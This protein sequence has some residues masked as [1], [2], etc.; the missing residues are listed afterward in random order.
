MDSVLK[1]HYCLLYRLEN[2]C[3]NVRTF[4]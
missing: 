3:H 2:C 1:V 4:C